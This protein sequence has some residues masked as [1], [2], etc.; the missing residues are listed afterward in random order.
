MISKTVCPIRGTPF[1]LLI[2]SR[3]VAAF[4]GY[5]GGTRV[6]VQYALI[7]TAPEV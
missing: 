2:L 7:G 1:R 6:K 5:G 4:V 3:S